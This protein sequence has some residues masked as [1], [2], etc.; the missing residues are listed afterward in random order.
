MGRTQ[1]QDN[2]FN[3]DATA[4]PAHL[5]GRDKELREIFDPLDSIA[6][7]KKERAPRAP[8][9]IIG[10]RGVGK[11][12]LLN[13]A[14]KEAKAKG[15]AVVKVTEMRDLHPKSELCTKLADVLRGESLWRKAQKQLD[16]GRD[17]KA[18]PVD[19][20][21]LECHRHDFRNLLEQ[22]LKKQPLA[23]LLEEAM[24]YDP[25][26]LRS[27]LLAWKQM[28]GN[29]YPLALLLAGTP[30]LDQTLDN[31]RAGFMVLAEHLYLS[32]LA[33]EATRKALR[34]PLEDHGVKVRDEA[35]ET[36]AGM[37]DDYPYFIQIAGAEVWKAMAAADSEEM[38]EE[39]LRRAA[40]G[41]Q[42]KREEFYQTN[43]G[44]IKTATL[45]V[46]AQH[47]IEMMHLN[48]G[49]ATGD[50][51]TDALEE[52][53]PENDADQILDIY[54]ELVEYGFV[55]LRGGEM[56][57]GIPPFFNYCKAQAK[58]AANRKKQPAT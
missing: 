28:A 21:I 48:D 10:P 14:E 37:T 9:K 27:V 49:R 30:K 47:V 4:G 54:N 15:I 25:D 40:A 18:A 26:A 24:D 56:E 51:I 53:F 5:A 6:P 11:T 29:K 8:V 3:P 2:P 34:R 42:K 39:I 58:K 20:S 13:E 31:A 19:A 22:C 7:D 35:L 32:G 17:V 55:W 52:R 33:P 43:C 50:M 41:I 46:Y 23:L 1:R 16:R 36:L 12:T 38:D 44:K 45:T 57:P